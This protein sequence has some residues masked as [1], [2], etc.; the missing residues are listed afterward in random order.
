MTSQLSTTT[1]TWKTDASAGPI[2]AHV[3]N[4]TTAMTGPRPIALIFHAGG[5]VLG[6]SVMIPR[7]QISYLAQRGFVIVVPEYRLCPQVSLYEGPIQDAKDVLVWCREELPALLRQ[8][9]VEIEIDTTKV[10]A[11]GHSAGGH[12]ALTTGTCPNPPLAILDFYSGK[13]FTDP[14]WTTPLPAF[15]Q[16]PPSEPSHTDK[17]FQGPQ[18]IASA[19]M[20][21]AAGPNLSDPRCAWFIEQIKSGTSM[22]SIVPD[23]DYTRIDAT[24]SFS[25]KFPP[26]Y[27]L[28]GK[29]DVFVPYGLSVRTHEA[30]KALG[31][32]TEL[33]MPDEIGH[34][35]DL[36]I[37]EE[38]KE[39]KEWV[40]PAL[41]WLVGHV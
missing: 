23:G 32:E 4:S 37:S 14:H 27:F 16:I 19:P 18:S 28:H 31:V 40:V 33:I 7:S 20:F 41:D 21:T 30:L 13:Y 6:S 17:I 38:A 8:E 3:H 15:S 5:F 2:P 22:S 11:M 35:F 1:L 10:V 34:A 39:F 9:N 12:L 25:G 24:S 29:K 26:T 36:Q